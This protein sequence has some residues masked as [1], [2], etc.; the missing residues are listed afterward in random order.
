LWCPV[1]L[2]ISAA[3]FLQKRTKQAAM[4]GLFGIAMLTKPIIIYTLLYFIPNDTKKDNLLGGILITTAL[5][6]IYL[7]YI[8]IKY[9]LGNDQ[10]GKD[11]SYDNVVV[12]LS[13]LPSIIVLITIGWV[14][15]SI[16]LR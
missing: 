7:G 1:I 9:S 11:I 16:I 13:F 6:F 3:L 15:I 12:W 4:I 5:V 10:K 14:Y 8:T 2:S